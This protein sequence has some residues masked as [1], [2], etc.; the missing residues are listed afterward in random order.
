MVSV[1]VLAGRALTTVAAGSATV[2]A[3]VAGT[4]L[5]ATGAVVAATVLAVVIG[6]G[7]SASATS[8]C[9]NCSAATGPGRLTVK[10]SGPPP[11]LMPN[12]VSSPPAYSGT[13]GSPV[14]ITV[15][16]SGP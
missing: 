7:L 6:G 14:S 16:R 3:S 13:P 4:A 1:A 2:V 9:S 11:M 5:A 8:F 15:D 10:P 12:E